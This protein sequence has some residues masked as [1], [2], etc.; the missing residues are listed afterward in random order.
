MISPI[1]SRHYE[2]ILKINQEFVHWLSPLDTE[3]L[4]WVLSISSYKRQIDEAQAV[5]F[6]YA[7][8]ADYPN[9]KNMTWLSQ[10]V[11][12]YFYIDR[13]IIDPKAQGKGYGRLLYEDIENFARKAGYS[14]I[15]CEV[16]TKPNNPK[17][18]AFH[19]A[20]GFNPIGD[21]DYPDYD[22]AL[23]YYIKTL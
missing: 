10:H 12:N 4:D 5:L 3:K 23:R 7:H 1:T 8:N 18:H 21:Q 13:I 22:A 20:M 15:T 9:H 14:N 11:V 19:L 2:Q 6:G 16:N 17:S